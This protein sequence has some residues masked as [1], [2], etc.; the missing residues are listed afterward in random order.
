MPLCN[1]KRW[2]R[3]SHQGSSAV[4]NPGT[5]M[6][7]ATVRRTGD[8]AEEGTPVSLLPV[9]FAEALGKDNVDAPAGDVNALADIFR[10]R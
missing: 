3:A 7:K 9:Q 8:I 1:C 6:V 4:Q 10:E 5:T 2:P